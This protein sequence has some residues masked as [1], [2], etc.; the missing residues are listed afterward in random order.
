MNVFLSQ[1]KPNT[2]LYDRQRAKERLVQNIEPQ[3]SVVFL[4]LRDAKTGDVERRPYVIASLPDRFELLDSG[5]ALYRGDARLVRLVAEAHRLNHAY[6][7]NPV[8]AT[9][10]SLIDPLP[11]QLVAVYGLPSDGDHPQGIQ[12]LLAHPHKPVCYTTPTRT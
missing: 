5:N 6:P 12:G 2:R 1:I 7:F 10:T 4:T 8:F 11:H 3:A 9:E